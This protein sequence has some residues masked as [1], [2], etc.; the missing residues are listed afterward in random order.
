MALNEAHARSAH[1]QMKLLHVIALALAFLIVG[2]ASPDVNP[3]TPKAG[4]G[5]V[6]FYADDTSGLCWQIRQLETNQVH[7]KTLLEEFKRRTNDTVRLAIT[8]GRHRLQI[9]FL[10]RAVM[11]PG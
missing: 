8:P 10:N 7:G 11:E 9:N 2:C 3:R 4:I 1:G 6:D 5:Y